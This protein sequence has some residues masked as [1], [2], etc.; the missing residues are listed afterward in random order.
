LL[1]GVVFANAQTVSEWPSNKFEVI[2]PA[3]G[4]GLRVK[5]NKDSKTNFAMDFGFGRN[6]SGG[7][8]FSLGEVF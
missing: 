2:S 8:F 4:A 3:A 5:L 1:G 6:G 7:V